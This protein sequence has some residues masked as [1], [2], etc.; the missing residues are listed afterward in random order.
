[1]QDNYSYEKMLLTQT[2]KKVEQD[3]HA[4]VKCTQSV[5]LGKKS[6]MSD[7]KL[8]GL[9]KSNN[10]KLIYWNQETKLCLIK[11]KKKAVCGFLGVHKPVAMSAELYASSTVLIFL[12]GTRVW[13]GRR[14]CSHFL[15]QQEPI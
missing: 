11:I 4:K 8:K 14:A 13:E 10:L 12:Q 7:K 2:G 9:K 1:M 5:K 3:E 15:T 6:K